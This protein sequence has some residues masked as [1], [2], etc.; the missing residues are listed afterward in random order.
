M[1]GTLV[2]ARD[3]AKNGVDNMFTLVGLT[4]WWEETSRYLV[5]QVGTGARE[6]RVHQGKGVDSAGSLGVR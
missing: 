2:G 1:P 6:E 5:C 3:S 4:C